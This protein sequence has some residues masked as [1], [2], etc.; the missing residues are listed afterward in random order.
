MQEPIDYLAIVN[1]QQ[2]LQEISQANGYYYD[3][4]GT[5]VKLDPN[6][7][8][9]SLMALDGPRPFIVLEVKPE[10]REY[11][12]GGVR[13]VV[14]IF[15]PVTVHWVSDSDSQ[16]DRDILQTF[17]RGCADVEK[18]VAADPTRGGYASDTRI[19]T[20]TN[21]RGEDGSQ[22]WAMVDLEI[23]TYRHYG[24]PSQ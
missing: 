12:G 5:A 4:R 2:A 8:T 6:H 23:W 20:C 22:V 13:G 15:R 1:L 14:T 9:E 10:R 17:F 18:A 16:R 11:G 7:D 3:V 19:V 24:E 21:D